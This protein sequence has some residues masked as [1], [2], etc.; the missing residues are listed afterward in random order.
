MVR[1]LLP[2][3]ILLIFIGC[4]KNEEE[5]EEPCAI[6]GGI[7]V[8][9]VVKVYDKL[10]GEFIE[11]GIMVKAISGNSA[12]RLFLATDSSTNEKSYIG[13]SGYRPG[14]YRVRVQGSAYVTFNSNPIELVLNETQC[15]VIQQRIEIELQPL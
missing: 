5:P 10:S 3:L 4:S 13:V 12:I 14:T 11:E 15:Q 2:A 1:R 7:P 9:L 6:S 8:G